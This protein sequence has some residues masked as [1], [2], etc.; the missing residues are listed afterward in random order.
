MT[1]KSGSVAWASQIHR[2]PAGSRTWLAMMMV[3]TPNSR[4][5]RACATVA[6]VI[7]QA[8]ASSC[9]RTSSGLIVV[10]A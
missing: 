10:F 8:P 9:R 1:K 3:S 5:M 2:I 7:A 6:A 4:R